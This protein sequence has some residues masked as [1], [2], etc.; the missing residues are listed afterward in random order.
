MLA[1]YLLAAEPVSRAGAGW[2]WIA[3]R[4]LSVQ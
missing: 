1:Q 4:A 3:E 2:F